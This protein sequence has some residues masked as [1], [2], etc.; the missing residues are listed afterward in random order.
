M[1]LIAG[2]CL[3]DDVR[4][5]DDVERD[6][7]ASSDAC[8][9]CKVIAEDDVIERVE[10]TADLDG[11]LDELE[12]GNDSCREVDDDAERELLNS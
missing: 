7:L 10:T 12:V 9:S 4:E 5:V 1:E 11:F 8:S 6:F 3:I 2:L